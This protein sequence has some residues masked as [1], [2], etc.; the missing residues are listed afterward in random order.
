MLKLFVLT[1][2]SA[3]FFKAITDQVVCL[4]R[5]HDTG[6]DTLKVQGSDAFEVSK[7]TYERMWKRDRQEALINLCTAYECVQWLSALLNVDNQRM[8]IR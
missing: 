5:I 6:S 2:H 4:D 8:G 1:F 7:K 3:T